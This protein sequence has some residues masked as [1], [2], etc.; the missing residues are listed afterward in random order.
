MIFIRTMFAALLC[1]LPALAAAQEN[2]IIQRMSAFVEAFNAGDGGAV[3]AFY[4]EDGV[5][6]V[7]QGG[8]V[9]GREALAR[10]YG[11]AFAAGVGGLQYRILEIRQAGP[12]TAVEIGETRVSAGGQTLANRSM[13]VWVLSDG[14]WYLSRDMYHVIGAVE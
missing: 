5:L 13:H 1:V 3:A 8:I 7:P 10:H 6:L 14:A 11:E 12:A 2:P 9:S 4:A